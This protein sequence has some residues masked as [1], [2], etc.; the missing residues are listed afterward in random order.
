[1]AMRRSSGRYTS[2]LLFM[3]DHRFDMELAA[4]RNR[5][6]ELMLCLGSNLVVSVGVDGF[7]DDLLSARWPVSSTTSR[8]FGRSEHP[9]LEPNLVDST[10]PART[11]DSRQDPAHGL[12]WCVWP[13]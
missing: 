1:M 5:W 11:A 8:D 12:R 3:T 4:Q 7:G 9:D 10:L 2:L 6:P 13:M